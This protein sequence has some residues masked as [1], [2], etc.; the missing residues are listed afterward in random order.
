MVQFQN[1]A[2]MEPKRFLY[3]FPIVL[4]VNSQH[5]PSLKQL[6]EKFLKLLKCAARVYGAQFNAGYAV[7]AQNPAPERIVQVKNQA[8][9]C[10]ASQRSK[11][12]YLSSGE[13]GQSPRGKRGSGQMPHSVVIPIPIT[14]VGTQP[15][16]VQYVYCRDG[17]GCFN[18]AQVD[19]PDNLGLASRRHYVM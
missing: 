10:S 4:A 7:L 18:E 19:R 12:S 11:V 2:W 16:V 14:N 1:H 5:H 9:P 13:G 8:L 6:K 15:L 17:S 3:V